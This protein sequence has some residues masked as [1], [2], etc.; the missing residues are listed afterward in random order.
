MIHAAGKKR[1]VGG[2]ENR[3][4]M[5]AESDSALFPI[6]HR[7][8]CQIGNYSRVHLHVCRIRAVQD[9]A[10]VGGALPV[11]H[12]L[13]RCG[14][15]SALRANRPGQHESE[16]IPL[17]GR[18][19]RV[20][21]IEFAVKEISRVHVAVAKEFEQAHV[22]LVSPGAR[23][24]IQHAAASPPIL[25]RELHAVDLHLQD[26]VRAELHACRAARDLVAGV[27]DDGAIHRKRVGRIASAGNGQAAAAST[28]RR[29]AAQRIG[30]AALKS[31]ELAVA[32]AVQGQ[33]HELALD[34]PCSGVGRYRRCGIALAGGS[35]SLA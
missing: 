2:D 30:N 12:D 6:D 7:V 35:A 13:H 4:G 1:F 10:G 25:G 26:R 17:E 24:R 9:V 21:G 18:Q 34:D 32:S 27:H 16:L 8:Q 23:D 14:P 31:C 11:A 15:V 3:L 19:P 22:Q 20:G 5:N 29:R 33:A 28:A